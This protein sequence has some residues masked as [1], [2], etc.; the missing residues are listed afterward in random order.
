MTR[1][2]AEKLAWALGSLALVLALIAAP[3]ARPVDAGLWMASLGYLIGFHWIVA[4]LFGRPMYGALRLQPTQRGVRTVVFVLG[5][6]LVGV[7]L[8]FLLGYGG[9]FA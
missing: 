2:P 6:A 4:Y 1:A 5:V 9:P 8:Q 7:A 3:A